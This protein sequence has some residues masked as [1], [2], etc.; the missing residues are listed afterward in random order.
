MNND[1]EIMA[2]AGSHESLT[3]ALKAGADS[4]YLGVGRLNMRARSTVNFT[5]EE[6]PEITQRCHDAGTKLYLTLNTVVYD[7]EMK[8]IRLIA[9]AAKSAN[10]DAVIASDQ[11]TI[12]YAHSIN[13]P[14]HISTQV[15]ISNLESVKFYSNF[16][17]VMVLARELNLDQVKYIADKIKEENVTGPSGKLVRLEMFAHGALCMAVSGKC[18]LSLHEWNKSAN[19][20]ACLQKCR[21]PYMVYDQ[22]GGEP[23]E[24]DNEYIM[25]PK[26][27][28]T[29]HFL[30]KILDSGIKVLKIEG[31]GR[32]PEYVKTTVE[33]Y[34]EAVDSYLDGTY[35]EKKINSWDVRLAQVFNRGFWDGYYLGQRLGE[36]THIYGSQATRKKVQI[37]KVTNYFSNKQIGE[38]Q[39]QSGEVTQGD[40]LLITGPTTG[41]VEL[42]VEGMQVDM[43]EVKKAEKGEKFSLYVSEKLRRSDKLFK[44]VDV[45][46]KQ[47][48]S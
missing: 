36:W 45:K 21:R 3:A 31:R 13:L 23:L 16:A 15:N 29:I 40:L 35:S 20:G 33:T 2:P 32:P 27:L 39:L 25:S 30:N 9:D 38:F 37:G 19:R 12:H 47:K 17:D 7:D 4:I 6:L 24:I 42:R 5:T 28:K 44:I 46:N 14:L 10:V 34:R 8:Q 41:A 22:D 11:A 18:Y 48:A 26:D 1:I 43:K